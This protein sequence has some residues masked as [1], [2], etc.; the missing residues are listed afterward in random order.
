MSSSPLIA[1]SLSTPQKPRFSVNKLVSWTVVFNI[2]LFWILVS[3]AQQLDRVR[4][5]I[6]FVAEEA[7]DLRLYSFERERIERAERAERETR[8]RER[9]ESGSRWDRLWDT[10]PPAEPEPAAAAPSPEPEPEP[11]QQKEPEPVREQEPERQR[12]REREP[13]RKG[14]ERA[15][16]EYEHRYDS[17][18]DDLRKTKSVAPGEQ[19]LGR[20]VFGHTWPAWTSHP[21]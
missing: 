12:E 16:Y 14:D 21:V 5:E 8:E 10:P 19:G 17:L 15:S 3:L 2:V 20:V 1:F 6:A 9:A 11:E 4:T 13:P 18:R 7:R